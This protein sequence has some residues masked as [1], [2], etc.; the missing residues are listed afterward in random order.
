MEIVTDQFEMVEVGQL[1]PHPKNPRRG[2]LTA[3]RQS[4]NANGFYGAIVAQRST[5][6]ILAGNHR[7]Q[8]AIA[9][10]ARRVPVLWVDVDDAKAL[11]ILLADNRT[12]DLAE[13][14]DEQLSSLLSEILQDAGTLTGTGYDPQD[15]DKL[16]KSLGDAQHE[17]VGDQTDQLVAQYQVLVECES[18]EQQT[19]LLS[20]LT[21]EGF[22]CRA[23]L[24]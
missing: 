7:F 4:I 16:L 20:R 22:Q 19:Q 24:S 12:G 3:I 11:R 5:R 15:L 9:E 8:A 13:N 6:Y 17:A 18:E 21:E 1:I 23:L 14:D 10:G 2:D